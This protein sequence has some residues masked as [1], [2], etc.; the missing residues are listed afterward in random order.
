MTKSFDSGSS[1]T[2]VFTLPSSIRIDASSGLN[3]F[4]PFAELQTIGEAE[5][6]PPAVMIG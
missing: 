4:I 5:V 3:V 6:L 2:S 1:S